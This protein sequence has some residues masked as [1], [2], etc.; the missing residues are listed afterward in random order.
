MS[1]QVT[2]AWAVTA[3]DKELVLTCQTTITATPTLTMK[4]NI[5]RFRIDGIKVMCLKKTLYLSNAS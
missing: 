5:F 4:V 3:G 1:L 2:P